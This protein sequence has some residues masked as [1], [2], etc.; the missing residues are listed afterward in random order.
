MAYY[1]GSTAIYP[2]VLPTSANS[3]TTGVGLQSNGSASFWAYPGASSAAAGSSGWRY[4]TILTHGYQCAGYKGYNPWRS[5]N[6]TWHQTDT[7]VY[8][9]EQIDRGAA[10]LGGTFS[11]YNGYVHGT[12]N[13][14]QGSAAH[15]SSYSLFNGV[16]RMQ[17][18]SNFTFFGSG[19][20]PY[21]YVGNNPAGE[22]LSYGSGQS[23]PNSTGGW[24]MSV[25][26]AV[27]DCASSTP[28][29][30]ATDGAGYIYGGGTAVT[31]KLHFPTEV[32]YSTTSLP[33]SLG[34]VWAIGG[35]TRSYI[36][37]GSSN[38]YCWYMGWSND[39]FTSWGFNGGYTD[40]YNKPLMTKW[41]H[42]YAGVYGNTDTR[43]W[44][45]NDSTTS[46]I[47]QLSKL[48]NFGEEN[49]QMGQD[50]GYMLG[51]Y[52]GQQNNWT[53]KTTY[54]NDTETTLGFAAQPKGHYGTSSGVCSS[55]AA[56]VC[57]VKRT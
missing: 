38:A 21:G 3:S 17:D 43:R 9:G 45:F 10:Y 51:N 46:Y 7:T 52:N 48:S 26:R 35:E 11:D 8:C 14:W 47:S 4:R 34:S 54:S 39:T 29:N 13:S 28:G 56:T 50:W 55:A 24:D 6:K 49:Q 41:G 2:G 42:F 40:G 23:S 33:T 15:T 53:T 16:L 1:V 18:N 30:G 27:H 32:M 31:D 22:G 12:S 19:G 25:A 57:G 36:T 5:V 20:A 44:K 37:G